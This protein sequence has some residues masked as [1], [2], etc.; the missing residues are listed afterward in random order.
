MIVKLYNNRNAI[1][2]II[3]LFISLWFYPAWYVYDLAVLGDGNQYLQRFEAIRKTILEFDQWPGN[4]PWNAGG[5]PIEGTPGRFTISVMGLLSIFFGTKTGLGISLIIFNTVGYFGSLKLAGVFWKTRY[6]HH[7]FALLVISNSAILFHLS[8][9][10]FNLSNYYLLPIIIYYFLSF[11]RDK[12]SGLKA[13][14]LLGIAFNENP[15]YSV[16]FLILIFSIIG[17][18]CFLKSDSQI[19]KKIFFWILTF[20]P[21]FGMI[22]SFHFISL[23]YTL[24]DFSRIST[25]IFLYPI[26]TILK[27]FFYPYTDIIRPFSDPTGVSAGSCTRSTHENS[28]YIGILCI[29]F[30]IA[31]FYKG[32]K[33]WHVVSFI[34]ILSSIG[35][36]NFLLPMYWI[37]KIP[38]YDSLGCFN[39]IRMITSIFITIC[40]VHGMSFMYGRFKDKILSIRILLTQRSFPIKKTSIVLTL[41]LLVT[42]E[43]LLIGHLIIYDT[44]KT[45]DEV[46]KIYNVYKKYQDN[47]NFFNLSNISPYEGT[48]NNIGMLRG[49]GDSHLPMDYGKN[50]EGIYPGTIGYD[51]IGYIGEFSQNKKIVSPDYWSPN[52]IRFS[53]LDPDIPLIV[54]MNISKFWYANGKK[55]FPNDRIIEVKKK[56]LV[57]S[58]NEGN[59]ILS[60]VYPGKKIGIIASFLFL[61]ISI[62]TVLLTKRYNRGLYK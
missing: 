51:E 41:I 18:I 3:F 16:Q 13:G 62:I 36:N 45:Y 15:T 12:W 27:S 60:Y 50:S 19:R 55:L 34:L 2:I 5:Q 23:L 29:P 46:D 21:V 31:S 49:G 47:K 9:G 57:F 26:D 53:N 4:N 56:F 10:H 37:Q 39:R 6:L 8:A 32:M 22:I 54:N 11:K 20:L 42:V 17:F 61:F 40:I 30:V 44:H 7:I 52:L 35:N 25:K 24:G 58:D 1:N 48:L 33:W 14:I 43:R 59:L 38:T 28:M